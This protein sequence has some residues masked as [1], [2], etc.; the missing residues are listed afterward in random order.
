MIDL[1][2]Y[3][4]PVLYKPTKLFDFETQDAVEIFNTL[5]DKVLEHGGYGLT[6]NQIGIPYS[7]FVFGNGKDRESLVAVFNPKIVDYS[8]DTNLGYEGCLSIPGLV[9]KIARSNTIRLR[10]QNINGEI[11]SETFSG[12]TAR[13]IQHEYCHI[14]GK[15]FF[16]GLGKLRLE[17]ATKKCKKNTGTIY[18]PIELWRLTQ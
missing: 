5:S 17:M 16:Y 4:N 11:L 18:N 14:N 10:Y 12:L 3:N 7:V 1:V 13:V 6:A 9:I 15:P 2:S 8:D